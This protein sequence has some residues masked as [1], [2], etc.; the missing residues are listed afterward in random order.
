MDINRCTEKVQEALRTAQS[1][2][3]RLSNQQ[4]DVEH[5][6][7]S[8]LEQEGGLAASVLNKADVNSGSLKSRLDQDLERLPKLSTPTGGPDQ[9][10]VATRLAKLL[11]DAE[12]EAKALKDEYVS[13]EHVL[14]AATADSGSTAASSESSAS[15]ESA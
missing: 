4:I 12:D 9:V 14:L 3:V 2:A 1:K 15:R 11:T 6:M 10:Y 13:V 8:L 7:S 5:L